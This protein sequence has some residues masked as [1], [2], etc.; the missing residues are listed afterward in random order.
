MHE[1]RAQ[2]LLGLAGLVFVALVIVAVATTTTTSSHASAAKVVASVHQHKSTLMLSAFVVGLAVFE[3][4][5]FFWYLREYLCDVASNRRLATV[6]FAGVILFAV[7]GTL[8]AGVRFS[9][10]D[11]V[12]HVD[13][14]VLQTL[15][16]L[17]NDLNTFIA[18]AGVAVFLVA[19][20]IAIIRNGPLPTWLGWVGV[21]LGVLAGAFGAPAAALWILIASIVILVRANHAPPTPAT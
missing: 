1:V 17:Q 19:N 9:M 6:A 16:V 10:V 11:A 2:R 20:G 8:G 14:V 3:A 12:G 7:S 15:N 5:F 4:L 13:P 21:V 18:G